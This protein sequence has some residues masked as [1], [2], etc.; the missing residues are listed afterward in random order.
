MILGNACDATQ[1]KVGSLEKKLIY[2]WYN[3]LILNAT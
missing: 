2:K 1:T 3:G